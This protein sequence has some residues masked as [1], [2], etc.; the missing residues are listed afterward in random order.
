MWPQP[1]SLSVNYLANNLFIVCFCFFLIWFEKSPQDWV[2][3]VFNACVYD[4]CGILYLYYIWNTSILQ[5]IHT[6]S[7][8]W[9]FWKFYI[10]I[11]I[12]LIIPKSQMGFC[13]VFVSQTF[14]IHLCLPSALMVKGTSLPSLS[15]SLRD[16]VTSQ[17]AVTITTT[18]SRNFFSTLLTQGRRTP[19]KTQQLNCGSSHSQAVVGRKEPTTIPVRATSEFTVHSYLEGWHTCWAVRS[20]TSAVVN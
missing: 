9:L 8:S 7:F 4:D 6:G 19:G 5:S 18:P 15:P 14:E 16:L 13:S 11:R 1:F 20:Y 12:Y 17:R 3:F 10:Y 2:L